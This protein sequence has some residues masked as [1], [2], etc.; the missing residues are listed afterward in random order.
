MPLIT[1]RS[2]LTLVCVVVFV[3]GQPFAGPQ[4]ALADACRGPIH[5]AHAAD[6]G[7]S[8]IETDVLDQKIANR[9]GGSDRFGLAPCRRYQERDGG[10]RYRT[11]CSPSPHNGNSS[12][13]RNL[14]VL[15]SVSCV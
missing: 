5:R 10:E 12:S 8:R 11:R 6:D 4:I 13:K 1:E 7:A 15:G 9:C 14:K 2:V 3:I